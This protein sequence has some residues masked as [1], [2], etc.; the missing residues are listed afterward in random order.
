M[1]SSSCSANSQCPGSSC[2]V[3]GG[4]RV[5]SNPAMDCYFNTMGGVANGT[6]D[7]LAFDASACYPTVTAGGGGGGSVNPPAGLSAI[8]H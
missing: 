8:V 1:Q 4:G 2:I 5:V 6:G 7:A 3:I